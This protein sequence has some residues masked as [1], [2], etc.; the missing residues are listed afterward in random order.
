MKQ[1]STF[2]LL[3]NRSLYQLKDRILS[4]LALA[5]SLCP[6]SHQIEE[7]A[8]LKNKFEYVWKNGVN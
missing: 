5:E 1:P 7:V 2:G 3:Q 8:L 4:I 6:M